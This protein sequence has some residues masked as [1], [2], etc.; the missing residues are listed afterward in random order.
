MNGNKEIFYRYV[1][2]KGRLGK[3][4]ALLQK[5]TGNLVIQD[6]EKAEVL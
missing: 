6:M 4:W 5:E 3:T 1:S 2:D